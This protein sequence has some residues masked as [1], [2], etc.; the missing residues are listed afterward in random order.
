M[1]VGFFGEFIR[2]LATPDVSGGGPI[3]SF[4]RLVTQNNME[5]PLETG[6]GT[7][8]IEQVDNLIVYLLDK[9]TYLAPNFGDLNFSKFLTYGY[10]IS[11]DRIFVA[12]SIAV[13]FCFGLTILGYF[14]LKTREI[15]K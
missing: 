15:A 7:T 3:E 8:L 13:G 9:L 6:V 14:C 1:I 2:E 12:V 11:N 10:S 4:F 5:T